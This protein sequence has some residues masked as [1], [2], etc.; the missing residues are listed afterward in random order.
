MPFRDGTGPPWWQGKFRGCGYRLTIPR[1]AILGVLSKTSKHLSAED[2]YLAVHKAYPAIGLTTIYRTLD[3]LVQIGLVFKFDFG[4]GRARYEL[5]EGP[6]G[7]S[8]H[9]HLV[10]TGC[11]RVID[12][13]DFIDE[14]VELLNRTEKGLSKKFNFRITNH[15][16]QFYGLC[17]RCR[18]KK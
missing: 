8:H 3:L 9:H 13:T 4:D 11:G 5:S 12:Y 15:L 7:A 14:E 18:S 10:C 17:D 1:E 16:I 2:V 6:K